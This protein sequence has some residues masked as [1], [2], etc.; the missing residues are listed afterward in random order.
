MWPR[1]PHTLHLKVSSS[2]VTKKLNT[3][4]GTEELTRMRVNLLLKILN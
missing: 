3:K 2:I 4:N 1:L